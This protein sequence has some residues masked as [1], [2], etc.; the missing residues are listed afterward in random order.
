MSYVGWFLAVVGLVG[1]I[2]GLMQML[3]AKKMSS[4]PFRK[5]SEI[6]GPQAADAKGLVSTEGAVQEGMQPLRGP[7]SGKPCLA[8]EILV[9]RKW[10]KWVMTEKGREKKTGTD[11][12]FSQ[13][14]GT[15]FAVTDPTGR[16]VVDSN[17][18]LDADMEKSH[19]NTV[20]GN[21]YGGLTFGSFQ[22]NANANYGDTQTTSWIGTEKIVSISPTLYVLGQLTPGAQ[23]HTIATPKGI[24]TGKLII[25][26]R[27]REK[28]L[29]STKTKM[30]VGYVLGVLLLGGGTTL[31][32]LGPAPVSTACEANDIAQGP[33]A[34]NGVCTGRLTKGAIEN[35]FSWNVKEAAGYRFTVTH[36]S[37]L[38]FPIYPKV[39]VTD[40][41]GKQ[42]LAVAANGRDEPV[43]FEDN[44]PVG[45]YK[46]TISDRDGGN[47][48]LDSRFEGGFSY[49]A[50][51]E[52]L[53]GPATPTAPASA[54]AT[55][56]PSA[57][58]SVAAAKPGTGAKP[59]TAATAAKPGTAPTAKKK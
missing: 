46:I 9:E 12:A 59:G 32:I 48:L 27:G 6:T 38:A 56:A 14:Y 25:S 44:V 30:I 42:V 5:P 40:S 58:A 20:M 50:R 52:K 21:V 41:T 28:L 34:K 26:H 15:T 47:I 55:A 2:F 36:P 53:K 35:S 1:V 18:S 11:K 43:G 54:S 49:V 10:E 57:V 22:F 31:G 16:V 4:V 23:G 13:T 51:L 19:T 29:K 45:K 7:M 8:A 3:K 24:G 39:V 17:G 37:G 33:M